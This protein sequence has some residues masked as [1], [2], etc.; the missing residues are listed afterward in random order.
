MEEIQVYPHSCMCCLDNM[1]DKEE[2]QKDNRMVYKNS[3]LDISQ[4]LEDNKTWI[5]TM[6]GDNKEGRKVCFR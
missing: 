6:Y 5:T 2:H 3:N 4:N 1:M